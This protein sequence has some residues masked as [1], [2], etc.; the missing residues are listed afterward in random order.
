M[1]AAAAVV[2]GEILVEVVD[3]DIDHRDIEILVNIAD[4][5]VEVFVEVG[6]Y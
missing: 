3:I 1:A 2:V 6:W 4:I 5:Q